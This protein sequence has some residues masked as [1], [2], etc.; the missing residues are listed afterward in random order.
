MC[1]YCKRFFRCFKAFH[2]HFHFGRDKSLFLH[3][4][5]SIAA[6]IGRQ[7]RGRRVV[8]YRSRTISDN[9]GVRQGFFY[10]SALHSFGV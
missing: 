9:V 8:E 1:S 4:E 10:V 5:Q 2:D 7:L 6:I 3:V